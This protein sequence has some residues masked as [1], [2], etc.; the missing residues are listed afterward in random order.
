MKL[1]LKTGIFLFSVLFVITLPFPLHF[2]NHPAF[3]Y[4]KYLLGFEHSIR[5]FL[6]IST[7][8]QG[9]FY[10]DSP[11]LG[12]HMLLLGLLSLLLVLPLRKIIVRAERLETCYLT[13]ITYILAFFLIKYGFDK[14]FK[15]QF[16]APEPNIL[17]TPF[18]AL[19]PDILYWSTMGK[20]Y[21]YC[22]FLG[23]LEILPGILLLSRKTRKLGA[24]IATGILLHVVFINFAYGIEVKMLSSFLLLLSLLLLA[25]YRRELLVF[26]FTHQAVV[27][28][29]EAEIPFPS[30][31][32]SLIRFTVIFYIFL[33]STF[34]AFS[35]GNLNDD[36]FPRPPFH[37]AYEIVEE[38]SDR[39]KIEKL[40]GLKSGENIRRMFIHRQAY[41]ILQTDEDRFM[42][43][44]FRY[45]PGNTSIALQ[46]TKTRVSFRKTTKK[47]RLEIDFQDNTKALKLS[48]RR[49]DSLRIQ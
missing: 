39:E 46:K 29:S 12:F 1:S 41:L 44:S 21:T 16:Y 35:T 15:L 34:L 24:L 4:E 6:G 42:D 8:F 18:G 27:C 11:D 17:Y 30:R 7:A 2:I 5:S 37:G 43:F 33:E 48:V 49:C 31:I 20:S 3:L 19:D 38:S 28:R 13:T 36:R 25:H 26:F 32:K 14:V 47:N 9:H 22:F 45:L 23:I 40:F 10:S